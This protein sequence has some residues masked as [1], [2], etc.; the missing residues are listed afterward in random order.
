MRRLGGTIRLRSRPGGG[1]TASFELPGDQTVVD[2]LWLE[3][4]G[5]R[6]ALPVSFTGRV[7]RADPDLPPPVRLARCLG[8]DCPDSATVSLELTVY[9]VTPIRVGVDGVGEIERVSLRALP[10]LIAERGP[11]GGAVLRRDGTLYLALDA[12]LVAARAW[13]LRPTEAA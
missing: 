10:D 7:E 3:E 5:Q 8:Q 12:P 2:V 11:Y 9:G 4:F 6:F 1:L 13:T